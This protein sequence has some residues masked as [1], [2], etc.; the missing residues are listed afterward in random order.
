MNNYLKNVLKKFENKYFYQK[1]YLDAIKQF[2]NSIND[3]VNLNPIIEEFNIVERIL[4]PDRII[5][6]KV[7]WVDDSGNYRVN[8]GY[9]VQ[10]SNAL[11]VYKGGT[12]FVSNLDE[13]VLK[14]LAFEQTF[15][16]SLTT[17]PLGGAK[18][19][20]DFN[21]L[22]KSINERKR[23]AQSY[24]MELYKYIGVDTDIP[25]GDLGV[26]SL[27][28]GYMYGTYKRLTNK[29]NASFTSKGVSYGGSLLRPE[30][31]GYGIAYVT[32]E[33]LKR[34]FNKD[35]KGMDVIISGSGQVG[36]NTAYKIKELGA[37]L[38]AI[39]SIY[40]VVYDKNGID[41]KLVDKLNKNNKNIKEYLK[42]HKDAK[43]Y[44]NTND[45]WKIKADI[46][47]PCATQHE[48]NLNDSNNLIKNNIKLIVEGS[49]K[50][51][52]NDA[53]KNFKDNKILLVPSKAA[54]SG[55]VIV[56]T[57][58]MEQ[59]QT[60]SKWTKEKVDKK[61]KELMVHIFNN[62]YDHAKEN[63]EIYDLEKT[64][65]VL[66]FKNLYKAILEQGL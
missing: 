11:G 39:S 30:S 37:N 57:L 41:I 25:A 44:K 48:L 59:N 3:Y 12:R 65:N 15:K 63:N 50:P 38:I 18:G 51:S 24:M 34:H 2:L 42:T 28:I 32:K 29:H 55:G 4:E 45:I 62:L 49:N 23:F 16:N 22:N 21:P 9:R 56:S 1:E 64:A 33:A 43:Y 53:I 35:I 61:L 5:S 8:K 54:N 13:S 14:F 7:P 52:T 26:S 10:H 17:L 20:S 40:G 66:A 46:A 31:T 6:F 36:I 27:E 60:F 58:E 47:I 19:G